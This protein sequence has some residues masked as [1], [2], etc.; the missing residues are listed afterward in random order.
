MVL[1][2]KS[3][4]ARVCGIFSLCYSFIVFY[5]GIVP[6]FHS[7]HS[8]I[9]ILS[10]YAYGFK[11]LVEI[12]Y[13]YFSL[14]MFNW[15][16][17]RSKVAWRLI[18]IM[19]IL[20]LICHILIWQN[21]ILF[22]ANILFLILLLRY[23]KIFNREIFIS[24]LPWFVIS[25]LV[26]AILYGVT[27]VY[28]LRDGFNGVH[29][30]NDALYF[31]FITYSTVG[32]GDVYP[33]SVIAK[34]LVIT[35]IIIKFVLLISGAT[36]ITFKINAKLKDL[37]YSLNKGKF[38]M[39]N[40]VVIVGEGNLTRIFTKVCQNQKQQFLSINLKD[41][42][43]HRKIL[44]SAEVEFAKKIIIFATSDDAAIFNTISV[45]EFLK[46]VSEEH[47]KIYVRILYPDNVAK[48]KL[49]GAD[50]VISPEFLIAEQILN[51][52]I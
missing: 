29:S 32:Y 33:T 4:I 8:E 14:I 52:E 27:G 45:K 46:S 26:F 3:K 47:P 41:S 50:V 38:G 40:H 16:I 49:V 18:F 44:L 43:D 5:F 24:Y 20:L 37:L 31:S 15:F 36:V 39:E 10:Y 9:A 7:R 48:A 21:I 17:K 35:M 25:L 11:F 13:I 22:I 28:V 6:I 12:L 51:G 2:N 1:S 30:M 23:R 19:V 34:N 42:D